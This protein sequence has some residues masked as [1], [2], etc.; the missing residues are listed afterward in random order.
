MSS[1]R[2]GAPPLQQWIRNDLG[3]QHRL[4]AQ[5]NSAS[6]KPTLRAM[7]RIRL[8]HTSSKRKTHL[9]NELHGSCRPFGMFQSEKLGLERVL[10]IL[11]FLFL[12]Q[13]AYAMSIGCP[14]PRAFG[15]CQPWFTRRV[16]TY[17][18]N[19]LCQPST[20]SNGHVELNTGGTCL[21]S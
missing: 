4:L 16:P 13:F 8:A 20:C 14:Q 11:L 7:R 17:T 9:W 18:R 19:G 3:L 2:K 10:S 5:G 21:T 12:H 1:R 6:S 15:T